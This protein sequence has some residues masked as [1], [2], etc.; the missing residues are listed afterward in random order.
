[1]QPI[2]KT[3]RKTQFKGGKKI[4]DEYVRVKVKPSEIK[5]TI[6]Q[7]N[8]WTEDQYRK[9]YDIF[10]NKLRAYE[11]YVGARKGLSKEAVDANRQSP[12]EVLYKQAKAKLREGDEYRP[13]I[14]MQRI[15]EFSAESITKGW[16][17][18][19]DKD[20]KYSRTRGEIFAKGTNTAFAAFIRDT[21]KAQEI[22]ATIEDPVKREE[23]LKAL[24]E[25]VHAKQSGTG[26]A[27]SSEAVG[28][29]TAG[30]DFDISQWL[31]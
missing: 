5:Q 8:N 23:A 24:A 22:V 4:A 16:K 31:E 11:S 18:A 28:S 30:E 21:P 1:M 12:I 6:M 14:K 15:Q 3:I 7:A 25:H 29:D 10:K 27:F 19:Q 20:S 17:K 13:S 26:E 2:Y 9:Q